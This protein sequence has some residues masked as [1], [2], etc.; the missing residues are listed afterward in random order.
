[1]LDYWDKTNK[2]MQFKVPQDV[3]REDQIIGPITLRQMIILG[4]GGG[5]AYALY[6]SLAKTYY[7]EIWFPP[8]AIVSAITLAF[9]FLKIHSLPFHIFLMNLIE[10]YI[11]PRNRFWVQ[12]TGTPFKSPFIDKKEKDETSKITKKEK[13]DLEKL[14][15][16]LDSHG[17]IVK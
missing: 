2:K 12:A 9:A 3:Q 4:V 8:V 16:V 7:A 11:L 1:M 13:K 5:I 10:Y 14:T 17:K 6:V 15:Q